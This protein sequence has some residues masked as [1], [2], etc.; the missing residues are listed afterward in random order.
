MPESNQTNQSDQ[1]Y[2]FT[3]TCTLQ[4]YNGIVASK[5]LTITK[6]TEF[7]GPEAVIAKLVEW[8]YEWDMLEM[9]TPNETSA[10]TIVCKFADKTF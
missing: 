1:P 5:T 10:F 7:T 2:L 3:A 8:V 9:G 6:V 4:T